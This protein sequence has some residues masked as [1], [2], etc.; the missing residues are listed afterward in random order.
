MIRSAG[1]KRYKNIVSMTGKINAKDPK[2][3][4]RSP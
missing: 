1:R 4:R 3:A 2:N